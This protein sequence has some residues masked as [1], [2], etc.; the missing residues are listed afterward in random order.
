MEIF[1][2]ICILLKVKNFKCGDCGYSCYLKTDLE[3]HISNVH[4]KH[5]SPCGVCG[6]KYSDLRQH[7][8]IVHEG[9]KVRLRILILVQEQP[10]NKN[11]CQAECPH[12][13]GKYS[14][15]S[16]HIHKVH[17][18]TK[19]VM[20]E[21]CGMTFYHNSNLKKHIETTHTPPKMI[22]SINNNY[23]WNNSRQG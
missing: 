5:R 16:Q 21:K 15:L 3:R 22:S 23:I 14:N 6:K 8:R 7:V 13:K 17:L 4:D 19:N 1:K 12:C 2:S 20:C 11:L 18:K 9:A 10:L